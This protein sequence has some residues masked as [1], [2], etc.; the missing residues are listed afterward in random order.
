MEGSSFSMENHD[1]AEWRDSFRRWLKAACV[2]RE[3]RED[4]GGAGTLHRNCIRVEQNGLNPAN[5]SRST[6]QTLDRPHHVRR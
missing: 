4:Y 6:A 1:P 3:D 2:H 5:N